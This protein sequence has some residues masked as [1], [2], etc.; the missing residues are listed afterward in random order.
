LQFGRTKILRDETEITEKN[1]NVDSKMRSYCVYCHTSPSGKK[2]IGI[3][4][5]KP[6]RRWRNGDGYADCIVFNRAIQKYG[7]D[8][9][10][11]EILETGLT[12]EEAKTKEIHY[13]ALFHSNAR[14][15]G[16]NATAGGDGCNGTHRSDETKKIL[17]E[18]CR[19][20]THTKEAIEKIRESS[21][22]NW[23]RDEYRARMLETHSGKN[24]FSYGKTRSAEWCYN[25]SK[26][27]TGKK[28]TIEW[29]ASM[30][31][32]FRGEG[33]PNYGRKFG[34]DFCE[35][36]RKIT[37]ER[38]KNQE[39]RQHLRDCF[40]RKIV[41]QYDKCGFLVDTFDGLHE[42]ERKTG[43]RASNISLCCRGKRKTASGYAWRYA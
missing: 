42:A 27:L 12:C 34:S 26:A 14:E 1:A 30:S 9:I 4:G 13:I 10:S 15:F 16:Y 20:F 17:S 35:L 41:Q 23:K 29:R 6:D 37:T 22:E 38:M 33:N 8:N 31:E 21:I 2:Y 7:W 18:K 19:G 43:I 24:H 28:H 40:E 25:L 3:T 5:Q 32:R 39:N 36:Q 11:H